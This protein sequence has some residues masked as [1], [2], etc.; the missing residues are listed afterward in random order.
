[1]ANAERLA[2]GKANLALS[3]IGFD[4]DVSAA[5]AYV[6]GDMLVCKDKETAQKLTFDKTVGVKSVTLDGDVYD[7]SGTLSGG[8]APSSSGLIVRVQEL[9]AIEREIS[10]SKAELATIFARLKEAKSSI[11]AYRKMKREADLKAHE[12]SL[13]DQEVNNSNG[14]R[15][16]SRRRVTSFAQFG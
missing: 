14:A 10:A 12:I 5:M 15:V 13:L 11:D 2:P 6:F 9:N 16:S 7:P 3:L 1:L 8:A 4:A